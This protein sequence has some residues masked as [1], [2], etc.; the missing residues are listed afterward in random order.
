MPEAATVDGRVLR[1]ERTRDAIVDALLS[2]LADGDPQ[3]SARAVAQR[4]GVSLRAVFQHFND[5]D[6]LYG[7]VAQRQV[8]RL[9]SKLDPLPA[10][11][12]PVEIRVDALVHQRSELF[13]AIGPVRRA[14]AVNSSSPALLR[15]MA[16]SEAFLRRQVAETFAAE[17]GGDA[18]RLDAADFA[19]SW[20]AW[21]ALRRSSRRSVAHASQIVRVQLLAV[22]VPT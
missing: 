18:G 11:T 2:Q 10:T 17:L 3:P 4:A 5:V 13:E 22:L 20:E 16:R 15:G 7:A 9:W 14:A 6:T 8:D 19:A 1:G 12:E 21:E